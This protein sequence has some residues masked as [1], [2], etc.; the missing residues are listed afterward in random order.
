MA[1]TSSAL[2]GR[3]TCELYKS[4]DMRRWHREGRL[5]AGRK[6]SWS[7]TSGGETSGTIKVRS[8]VDA[9]VLMLSGAQLSGR[10]MEIDRTASADH[11]D[12]LPLRRPPPLVYLFRP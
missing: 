6:F 11:M 3:D 7:W 5:L 2:G 12:Q 1:R 9:V 10:W 4:I 8:E